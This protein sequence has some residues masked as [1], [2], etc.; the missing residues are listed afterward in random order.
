MR[1]ARGPRGLALL[2]AAI[3][4]AAAGAAAQRPEPTSGLDLASIDSSARPQ[5][6]LFRFANGGWLARAEI[7]ADRV[8]YFAS[9]ELEERVLRDLHA[10]ITAV[11]EVAYPA[12]GSPQQQIADLYRSLTNDAWI[13]ALGARPMQPQLDRIFAVAGPRDVAA[14]AG[15]LGSIG[16]GGPFVASLATDPS[17][18]GL[19]AVMLMQSGIML[20]D[21][22]YYLVDREPYL[23]ARRGYAD[24]LT[25]IFTLIGRPRPAED[26][27][28][29]VALE[30][31]LAEAQWTRAAS[32]DPR[33]S[34]AYTLDELM[35]AMPG[36]DWKAWAKPQGV[37]RV[38]TVV[39]AQPAFFQQ[40]AALVASEPLDAWKAWLAARY[41]T[42]SAPF[43]SREFASA[44][45]DFFGKFLTGQ[46]EP[47]ERWKRGVSLVSGYLGEALGRLYVDKHFPPASKARVEKIVDNVRRAYR[48][49]VLQLDWMS[50]PTKDEALRKLDTLTTKIGSPTRWRSYRGLEIRRD[51]LV[52]NIERA[53]AFETAFRTRSIGRPADRGSWLMTPQTVNA[54]YSPAQHE[55]VFPAAFLQPPYFNPAADDAVNYGALG[56]VI[57]HEIG[58][59][60]DDRGRRFDSAGALRDWWTPEDDREFR[61]RTERLVAQFSAYRPADGLA[62]DGAFTLGENFGDLGG[63]A[64]AYRAWKLAL[65][66]R[67][68][69]VIDG[70]TGDQRFFLGWAQMWRGK[71]RP[72]FLRQFVL[73]TPHAP[74]QFR[75]NG[76]VSNMPEFY[77]AFGLKPG[78]R[79]FRP[80]EER[81]RIW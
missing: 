79:L 6:D 52:G 22:D 31:R 71:I 73:S 32:R 24:Y 76:P 53:K 2:A 44:R 3:G 45:F 50:T 41:I 39:L 62:L 81:V 48:R 23:A 64:I 36:F 56:A 69:P 60:L 18:P 30:T 16:T 49:A 20:P 77:E 19:P 74:P 14:V 72:E 15:H 27:A 29:L 67:P 75:A 34:A 21:R 1:A 11:A 28:A 37:D 46:E 33:S 47:I 51:D 17:D 55:I 66:N 25:R 57:G 38:R 12:P 59:A 63:L 80:P 26:A 7:P 42:A 4:C 43:L 5:D 61:R 78:D 70:F 68:A 65:G 58:H 9:S 13:E 35:A 8:S 54:Y 10:I 40:F